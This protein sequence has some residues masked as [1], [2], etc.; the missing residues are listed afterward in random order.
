MSDETSFGRRI[1]E[2]L[3]CHPKAIE[4]NKERSE[5]LWLLAGHFA[6]YYDH[7]ENHPTFGDRYGGWPNIFWGESHTP[8]DPP[9]FLCATAKWNPDVFTDPRLKE[10]SDHQAKLDGITLQRWLNYAR[11]RL[12]TLRDY[13]FF[14][15]MLGGDF[16]R[17][18]LPMRKLMMVWE[19]SRG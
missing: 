9:F 7:L 12:D 17:K 5:T 14:L 13:G 10:W 1:F 11:R 8:P 19:R 3:G 15:L 6:R 2:V 16:G 4:E 18:G